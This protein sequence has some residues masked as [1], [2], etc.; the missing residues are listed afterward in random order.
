MWLG[1]V[2]I[3]DKLEFENPAIENFGLK[4]VKRGHTS[5]KAEGLFLVNPSQLK[6]KRIF[7]IGAG[8]G[9]GIRI[10]R[11]G[12]DSTKHKGPQVREK[13]VKCGHAYARR[14]G[15]ADDPFISNLMVAGTIALLGYHL[16]LH[17]I[18][19]CHF[20]PPFVVSSPLLASR[21]K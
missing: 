15:S 20:L 3:L 13:T 14:G 12:E 10:V 4:H 17:S 19:V 9:D 11:P 1:Q 6:N 2:F 7:C 21:R 16:R 18:P 5:T 8:N